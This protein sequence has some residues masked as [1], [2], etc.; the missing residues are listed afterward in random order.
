MGAVTLYLLPVGQG[1]GFYL[2]DLNSFE[3]VFLKDQILDSDHFGGSFGLSRRKQARAIRTSH[4]LGIPYPRC[5][6]FE[7]LEYL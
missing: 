4:M 6:L 7:V 1:P 3:T 5:A 2:L